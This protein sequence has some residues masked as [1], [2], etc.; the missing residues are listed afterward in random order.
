MRAARIHSQVSVAPMLFLSN[1]LL[2]ENNRL[3]NREMHIQ[4]SE[5]TNLNAEKSSEKTKLGSEKSSEKI[6]QLMMTKANITIKEISEQIG[7]STRAIEKNIS[8][9]KAENRIERIGGDK[10]GQWKII[11]KP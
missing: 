9:L 5:R 11:E 7:L 4:Y 10:G 2:K 8:K 3:K 1:L 6:I